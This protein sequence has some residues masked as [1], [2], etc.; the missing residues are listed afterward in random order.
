MH[1]EGET[2]DGL[3]NDHPGPCDTV[4]CDFY[5]SPKSKNKYLKESPARKKAG[6]KSAVSSYGSSC[7]TER[8]RS[9]QFNKSISP[10][11]EQSSTPTGKAFSFKPKSFYGGQPKKKLTNYYGDN[12]SSEEDIFDSPPKPA[13]PLLVTVEEI[14]SEEEK[15]R[16][17][18]VPVKE[19]IL[20]TR[21]PI[22]TRN[23]QIGYTVFSTYFE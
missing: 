12:G 9:R 7:G 23:Y 3:F 16:H 8:S 14:D 20:T 4:T 22:Q 15:K 18:V 17:S 13:S 11:S 21:P 1:P 5:M 19:K 10:V 2:Y 6:T